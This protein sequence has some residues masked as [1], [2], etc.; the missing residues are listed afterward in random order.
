MLVETASGSLQ[1]RAEYNQLQ[2]LFVTL[3]A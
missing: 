2:S 3:T 1:I